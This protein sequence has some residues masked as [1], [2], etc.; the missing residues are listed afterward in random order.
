[1]TIEVLP[2]LKALESLQGNTTIKLVAWDYRPSTISVASTEVAS[3]VQIQSRWKCEGLL[4]LNVDGKR[5]DYV[6]YSDP[7]DGTQSHMGGIAVLDKQLK[8]E[9]TSHYKRSMAVTVAIREILDGADA[10]LIELVRNT[11][12]EAF[13]V[14]TTF[15]A[16]KG[17]PRPSFHL[18][19]TGSV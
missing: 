9:Q 18:W 10:Y 15:S 12:V 11:G 13:L 1:M 19:A 8:L 16:T 17:L 5:R 6:I 3:Q 14:G 4:V 2:R 7:N